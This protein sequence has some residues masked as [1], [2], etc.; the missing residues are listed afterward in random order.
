[1]SGEIFAAKAEP[2]SVS[3]RTRLGS[4]RNLTLALHHFYQSV[5]VFPIPD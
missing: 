1:M 4:E 3:N 2:F 5:L